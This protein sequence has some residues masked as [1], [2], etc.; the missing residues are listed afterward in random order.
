MR[1]SNEG[2][3]SLLFLCH[4]IPFPPNKGDKIR[5]YHLL[6]YL[7]TRYRVFLATF[8]DD[9]A[10]EV[11]KARVA[12][13]CEDVCIV[14]LSPRLARIRSAKA[15]LTN[16]PLSL[17]YYQDH[18]VT[19]WVRD[20]TRRESIDR[21]LVFSSA[22][23]Q[24]AFIPELSN[25]CVVVDFVDVDSDKWAQYAQRKPAW[26]AWI[27]RLKAGRLAA[28][29][30]RIARQ[31]RASIFVSEAEAA[32]FRARLSG[33]NVEVAAVSNGVDTDYFNPDASRPSP[34]A[35]RERSIVFTGAM[36]YWA[37]VDAV[38]W[39]NA[40]ILPL[41]VREEPSARFYIVGSKPTDAVIR[42]AGPHTT[43]TGSVPDVRPYLEHAGA[44]VAPMRIARGIQNKVLEGMAMAK[45]VITTPIGLEGIDAQPGK[46]LLLASS[47]ES[48]ARA[49]T[50]VLRGDESRIAAA[51]RAR[52]VERYSWD[53]SLSRFVDYLGA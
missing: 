28:Y 14:D 32:L 21:V 52:V 42:L 2:K 3:P 7:S 5:S 12:E 35:A 10:D 26:S 37:N 20:L 13:L 25:A 24:Y 17:P 33:G 47:A 44:V 1:T 48:F 19:R 31:A 41:V 43:V 45:A 27:Y 51:A 36:D 11:H 22:M 6:R 39:F 9:P 29:E 34:F 15:V 18:Q 49:V 50:S 46:E 53:S 30:D 16:Q 8:I 40:E 4:R 23:A 38:S